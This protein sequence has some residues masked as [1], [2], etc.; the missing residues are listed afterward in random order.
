MASKKK[1]EK[2]TK[3]KKKSKKS[4]GSSSADN[5]AKTTIAESIHD[6]ISLDITIPLSEVTK[7]ITVRRFISTN[8]TLPTL[9][10]MNELGEIFQYVSGDYHSYYVKNDWWIQK[11]KINVKG[12]EETMT[13]T[14]SPFID[15]I[16]SEK[17]LL[18][19]MT[20]TKSSKK[21]KST[22]T[23]SNVKI[24]GDAFLQDIV[25]K[26]IGSKTDQKSMAL[27]CYKYY[28]DKH[29]YV[30]VGTDVHA[31]LAKGFKTLWNTYKHSCGPGA[32]TLYYMFRAIGLS[33]KIWNGHNHYWISVDI[34]GKTY[35]CDQA[36][37]EGTHNIC[38]NGKRRRMTTCSNCHCTVFG[39]AQGGSL[40]K[41]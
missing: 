30:K 39:G 36:G 20:Q 22:G 40:K 38:T 35:Y 11:T 1:S 19:G 3:K 14:L 33:P 13:L 10:N 9:V 5:D 8:L 41:S 34:D 32:A 21:T 28:Q 4:K 23:T 2:K 16:S 26:A 7:N 15:D 18:A 6:I 17:S 12:G 31:D 27:A 37:S 29:V 25:R 24:K